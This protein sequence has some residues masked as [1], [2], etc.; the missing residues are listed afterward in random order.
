MIYARAHPLS[1]AGRPPPTRG[2]GA[3]SVRR[4]RW[5][6][7]RRAA[8]AE[9]ATCVGGDCG[10]AVT[11]A[12]AGERIPAPP[13]VYP[14]RDLTSC[15]FR[16]ATAAADTFRHYPHDCTVPHIHVRTLER[17]PVGVGKK[18]FSTR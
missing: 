10:S 14:C 7:E 6:R 16:S 2:G 17:A 8:E 4:R 9:A 18:I 11:A 3:K 1:V 13:G 15:R 5:Q 12:A